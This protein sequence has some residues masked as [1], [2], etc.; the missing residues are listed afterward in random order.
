MMKSMLMLLIISCLGACANQPVDI[1]IA[2]GAIACSEPRPQICTREY[3]PVCGYTMNESNN[4]LEKT[5][6]N[7]CS[8]CTYPNVKAYRPK[9]CSNNEK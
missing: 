2:D 9:A 8:A 7:G 5:Y 3:R 6:S 1:G 4:L